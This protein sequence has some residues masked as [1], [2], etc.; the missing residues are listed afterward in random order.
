MVQGAEQVLDQV[1]SGQMVPNSYRSS[2]TF[3]RPGKVTLRVFQ[4][5]STGILAE[6]YS[7]TDPL[8]QVLL[9]KSYDNFSLDWGTGDLGE[10]STVGSD[11]IK[12]R[13]YFGIKAPVTSDYTFYLE[14]NDKLKFYV[15]DVQVTSIETAGNHTVTVSMNQGEFYWCKIEYEE[16][17]GEALLNVD[18]SYTGQT[19]VRIPKASLHHPNSMSMTRQWEVACPTSKSKVVTN[20]V[21]ECQYV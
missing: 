13:A 18:W 10:S 21:P 11:N 16:V 14:V 8:E 20:G 17:T 12:M 19:R 5:K 1:G 4:Y 15:K 7:S 9:T 6:F 3:A 2:I